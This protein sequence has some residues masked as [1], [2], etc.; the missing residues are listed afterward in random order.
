MENS[1]NVRKI[2]TTGNT[3]T[4]YVTL[5]KNM[6]KNLNWHKGQ[7]VVARQEGH[8]II[9]EDYTASKGSV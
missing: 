8:S 2:T 7:R 5:P 6:V 9:I 1:N 4:Y 3:G